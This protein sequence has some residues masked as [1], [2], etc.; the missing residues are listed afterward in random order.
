V[1]IVAEKEWR[2][3]QN[4]QAPFFLLDFLPTFSASLSFIRLEDD[5]GQVVS[6]PAEEA[7]QPAM[8]LPVLYST[9]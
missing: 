2:K 4:A 8:E 6:F 7:R 9:E 5:L 3:W 1:E